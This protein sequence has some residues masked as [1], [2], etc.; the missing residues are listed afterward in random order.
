MSVA[1]SR[2]KSTAK[3]LAA[4]AGLEVQR[5]GAV[6]RTPEAVLE[7]VKRLGLEPGSVID[8][9]V[10][11]GTPEL[12]QA[13]PEARLLLVEPLEEYAESV[14]RIES[15]HRAE[16]VRAAAGPG[17]GTAT[18]NVHR[19]PAMSSTL[20]GWKGHADGG[21]PREVPVVTVDELV[22]ERRLPAPFVLKVDVE[23][24]ELRVLDGARRTLER[25]E[26]VLLE[27]CLFEFVPGMPQLH[28][29]VGYMLERGFVVY[30]MFGGHLRLLDEAL[31]MVNVAFVQEGGR[32]RQ[33]HDFATEEQTDELFASWG[34]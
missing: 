12:Y 30:D 21:T 29:V 4:R 31:A 23:G 17:R 15:R 18:M 25:T 1:A 16:W 20:G 26:L 10:A 33:S 2:L 34:F 8:V 6:R 19:V 27:V 14:R 32:F 5:R 7:H 9:G 24:A 28:E 13:F 3:R 22:E 11:H